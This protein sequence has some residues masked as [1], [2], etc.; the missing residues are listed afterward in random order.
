MCYFIVTEWKVVCFSD[1][2]RLSLDHFNEEDFMMYLSHVDQ[3]FLR[4]WF[5]LT[6][7]VSLPLSCTD[8][9]KACRIII[10]KWE[11]SVPVTF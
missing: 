6:F 7:Y 8:V 4:H 3:F 5:V 1:I 2:N 11:R 9:V 10:V